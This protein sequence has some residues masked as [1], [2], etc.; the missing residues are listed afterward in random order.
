MWPASERPSVTVPLMNVRSSG[1]VTNDMYNPPRWLDWA[2]RAARHTLDWNDKFIVLNNSMRDRMP[3]RCRS[4]PGRTAC[5]F[6]ASVMVICDFRMT[7]T[8][9]GALSR[10]RNMIAQA[11][12]TGHLSILAARRKGWRYR[13]HLANAEIAWLAELLRPADR[14]GRDDRKA[15]SPG[16]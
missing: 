10:G 11:N 15:A 6:P 5:C 14:Y 7:D 4:E 13:A 16:H 2:G 12:D 3:C 1:T 9:A 8:Q